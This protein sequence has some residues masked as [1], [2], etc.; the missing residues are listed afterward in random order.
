MEGN[1]MQSGRLSPLNLAAPVLN[2]GINIG[3]RLVQKLSASTVADVILIT[4]FFTL[5]KLYKDVKKMKFL[6]KR[7]SNE[8]FFDAFG[9]LG[10]ETSVEDKIQN[11]LREVEKHNNKV[12]RLQQW[13]KDIE[14]RVIE[15]RRKVDI[16]VGRT[17]SDDIIE[18]AKQTT[19]QIS[20]SEQEKEITLS[21]TEEKE[22]M[23]NGVQKIKKGLNIIEELMQKYDDGTGKIPTDNIGSYHQEVEIPEDKM[24]ELEEGLE[25]FQE[26]LKLIEGR[27]KK[28]AGEYEVDEIKIEIEDQDEGSDSSS[29]HIYPHSAILKEPSFASKKDAYKSRMDQVQKWINEIDASIKCEAKK[30]KEE[31]DADANSTDQ[32]AQETLDPNENEESIIE[33]ETQANENELEQNEKT[34]NNNELT[35]EWKT[36]EWKKWMNNMEEKWEHF[37]Q[38]ME[39]RKKKWIQK[40]EGEWEDWLTNMHYNWVAFINKLEGDYIND[41]VN[42]WTEWGEKDWRGIIEMEWKRPM[43]IKWINLLKNSEEACERKLFKYWD[44]WKDKNWNKWKNKN[45]KNQEYEMWNKYENKEDLTNN[46]NWQKWKKRLSTEKKEWEN[47]VNQKE[48]LLMSTE[49]TQWEKWK[50]N[51]WNYL[52]QWMKRVQADWLE[53]KPWE[54]WKKTRNEIYESSINMEDDVQESAEEYIINS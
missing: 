10:D 40:K 36:N 52:I 31:I 3:K 43:K 17:K 51:K 22:I 28:C 12:Q 18:R 15:E 42:A 24:T 50:E 23:E 11:H 53:T 25:L 20:E 13:F 46:E 39:Q 30:I 7:E 16:A 35:E 21:E 34:E 47:W 48:F 6:Q 2:E 8:I 37:T 26:G 1:A 4:A 5:Y 32:C 45:W 41:A 49:W 29:I 19:Q 9:V 33:D 27:V 14:R 54:T 44:D 38:S